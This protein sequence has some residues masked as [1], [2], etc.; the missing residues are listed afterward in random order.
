MSRPT[1]LVTEWRARAAECL[2]ESKRTPWRNIAERLR[3]HAAV[4]TTCADDLE[5][6][7]ENAAV[8][9]LA[10]HVPEAAEV[11]EQ[12]GCTHSIVFEIG[13]ASVQCTLCGAVNG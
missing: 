10:L 7:V 1:D 9:D 3:A 4:Y 5:Q 8:E 2:A 6:A 11:P 12:F 13:R